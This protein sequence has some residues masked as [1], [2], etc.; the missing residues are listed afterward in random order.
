MKTYRY[1]KTYKLSHKKLE[2][3]ENIGC[4][5][6]RSFP[7]DVHFESLTSLD[8][9]NCNNLTKFGSQIFGNNITRLDLSG[10]AIKELHH[11]IAHLNGLKELFLRR[12]KN[13]ET[14][15]SGIHFESLTSLDLSNC[16]NLTKFPQISG[17]N[18]T[19][20]DLSGTAIKELHHFISHLN[21][22]KALFLRR[23]ENLETLPSGIHFESL[24]SLDLSNC[25]NLTKFPQ[26]SGNNIT[27]LDLSGTAIK[28]L[29][30]SISH[31]N[32]LKELFLRRCKNLETLP[33]GIHFES[34]TSLDLSN[35]NNLTKFPQISGNNITRLD[36]SGTAIKELHH[37][38]SHLNGLKELFLR[39][40]KN[41]ETLPS[42]IHFE[43][44]TSL[45]LS[46]CNNLTKFPQ[47]SSN[48][49]TRLDLSGTAIKE[50]H[51]SISHLNGLKELF[52]R[53]C[54]NLETLPSGIHFESLTSLDLS[55]CNNLTKF[56]EISGNNITR[57]DLSG[58]AIKELHHSISHLNG[59]KELF[60][61][62]C[63]NLETLPSG[64]HFESLTSLDLSNCNNLTKFPQISSNNITR[65]DLSG[66]AIKELHHSISHLN[67]LKEL[68]LRRLD[69]SGTAIKELHHSISHLNGLKEL[70]LRRCENLETLPSGIHFESLTS[71]D[72][73][74]CNN[75]T[76]FPQ[77]S[78]N[79]ITW[80]DLSG[81]AIK[82][83]HHSISHL[84]GLKELFLRRCENLETLPSGIH[85]ESLTSLDLSNCNNLT[86]FPQISGNNITRLD[87][88]GTAIKELHH[89][90][91]H[92]NGLKELFLRRCKNLETLPSGIHFESLTSLDLSS[93]NNL[94]KFPQIS[95]NNITR[96]DLSGTAIKELHHSISHLN[97]L[98]ELFLRRAAIKELPNSIAHLNGL[99]ALCL[100]GCKNLKTLPIGI[101]NLISLQFLDIILT[102]HIV[103]W[104][105]LRLISDHVAFRYRNALYR[106]QFRRWFTNY[107][108]G[109]RLSEEIEIKFLHE[110]EMEPHPK[111]NEN[112]Q[113]VK[114][115][116]PIEH[117]GE[118][119]GIKRSHSSN[120]HLEEEV[121]P[122]P[123]RLNIY[124]ADCFN[125]Y[126]ADCFTLGS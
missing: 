77:I 96:L 73:S 18:I 21:G 72:L 4:N 78:G 117:I 39:R 84:N 106:W 80:L 45:D 34:L 30:H 88:S 89:S 13:L 55:N 20:F 57:L 6:L 101:Y 108:F 114:Y 71:L 102:A 93:C 111:E 123:K 86:K 53:R 64:I 36:L 61:R 25:N 59:L 35:C 75:L 31:L 62:R 5:S 95:G 10:T 47:I 105:P 79:N 70:F 17:N 19:R 46:N 51:H 49:I 8:F 16:N 60:L 87:L 1:M 27:W 3:K 76:K 92:L 14:L 66:T 98:K 85:F 97:G 50:L 65:L 29:H 58:T 118:T 109:F 113:T 112:L 54:K 7:S 26:I 24:T 48:N 56:P 103:M 104:I 11:S 12:C 91:S 41:L 42:G 119:N 126:C 83:L 23:C 82:E 2:G 43:S 44:L 28:E 120:D 124:C 32:G 110:E 100:G 81:T 63:E 37:S 115:A 90:I 68:F 122:H 38:I 40:C 52:L 67:G 9:S 74:N 15:P 22:L 33:S 116:E 94:T 121:E 99:V 125:I 107:I 69:L